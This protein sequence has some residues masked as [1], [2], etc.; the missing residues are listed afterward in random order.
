MHLIAKNMCVWLQT[1]INEIM[2][3]YLTLYREPRLDR[4][5][6]MMNTTTIGLLLQDRNQDIGGSTSFYGNVVVVV[7][8]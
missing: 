3:E 2:D 8:V 6:P 4:T 1:I 7:S 5:T